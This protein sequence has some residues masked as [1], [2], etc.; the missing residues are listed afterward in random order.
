M[1]P[2]GSFEERLAEAV[3]QL[4]E[5]GPKG[6]LGTAALHIHEEVGRCAAATDGRDTKQ[7]GAGLETARQKQECSLESTMLWVD[8]ARRAK[9]KRTIVQLQADRA[10]PAV[11]LASQN[12]QFVLDVAEKDGGAGVG[13]EVELILESDSVIVVVVDRT[14]LPLFTSQKVKLVT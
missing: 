13:C 9:S 7:S 2:D 12:R 10:Y 6:V 1:H 14:P 3:R 11:G 4:L 8:D 5:D